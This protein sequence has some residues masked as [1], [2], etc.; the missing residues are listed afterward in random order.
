MEKKYG[1]GLSDRMKP[2]VEMNIEHYEYLK[3]FKV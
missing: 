3:Q 1:K 2:Y